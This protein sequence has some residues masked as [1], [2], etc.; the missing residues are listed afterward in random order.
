ML[1]KEYNLTLNIVLV[2]MLYRNDP[3]I[4]DVIKNIDT[5]KLES[6]NTEKG[7]VH[8]EDFSAVINAKNPAKGIEITRNLMLFDRITLI[9]VKRG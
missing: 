1:V 8:L 3:N 7:V 2:D 6:Y 5:S 9:D 4:V